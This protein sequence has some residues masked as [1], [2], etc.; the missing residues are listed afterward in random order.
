MKNLI[1][2]AAVLLS[3]GVGLWQLYLK[4]RFAKLIVGLLP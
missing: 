4:V 2:I 1:I 3:I